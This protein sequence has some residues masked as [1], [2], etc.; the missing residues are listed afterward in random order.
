MNKARTGIGD[1]H[2]ILTRAFV[3]I[4]H[5]LFAFKTFFILA[6]TNAFV[7]ITKKT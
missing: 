7:R 6:K 2:A 5:T 1:R 3:K 4:L